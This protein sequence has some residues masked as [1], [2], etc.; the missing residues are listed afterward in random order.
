L[1]GASVN[2]RVP[3][4]HAV[5]EKAREKGYESYPTLSTLELGP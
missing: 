3:N 2:E 4:E 1:F 5:I